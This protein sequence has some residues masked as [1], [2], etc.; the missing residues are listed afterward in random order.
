MASL[1]PGPSTS[2]C[3]G[4]DGRTKKREATSNGVQVKL[5]ICGSDLDNYE[6]DAAN[7]GSTKHDC[8]CKFTL[9]G[10]DK[11][12][13]PVQ[14][15]RSRTITVSSTGSGWYMADSE[16]LSSTGKK[17]QITSFEVSCN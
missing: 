12:E 10:Q 14:V 4:S 13:K 2:D 15:S 9:E 11:E 17:F 8:T 6:I 7:P 5:E 16:S 3:T 1:N